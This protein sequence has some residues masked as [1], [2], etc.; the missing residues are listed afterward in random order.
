MRA[1]GVVIEGGSL[2]RRW[3]RTFVLLFVFS[4]VVYGRI[5][6]C[7]NWIGL[8]WPLKRNTDFG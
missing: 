6:W 1:C 2:P 7:V 4:G 5:Y 8:D 3:V